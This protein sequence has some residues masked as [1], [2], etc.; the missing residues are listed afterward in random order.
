MVLFV[1]LCCLWFF[2]ANC[3]YL[4]FITTTRKLIAYFLNNYPPHLNGVLDYEIS[5]PQRNC[6]IYILFCR[7]LFTRIDHSGLL[8]R[9]YRILVITGS[10]FSIK[11]YKDYR[12]VNFVMLVLTL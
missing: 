11:H 5:G 9:L 3:I 2:Y 10:H 4:F 8:N 7:R 6:S 1:N 12:E